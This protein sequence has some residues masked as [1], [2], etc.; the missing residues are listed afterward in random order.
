MYR[1]YQN[2]IVIRDSSKKLLTIKSVKKKKITPR[3]FIWAQL[4]IALKSSLSDFDPKFGK[5]V[6]F[7]EGSISIFAS[8]YTT[9][10]TFVPNL[11]LL[12]DKSA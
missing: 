2:L 7:A 4:N 12:A 1:I 6:N 10:M 5:F 9:Y 8:N 11:V 3:S